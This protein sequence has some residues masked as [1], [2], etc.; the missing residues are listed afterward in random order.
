M[1][2]ATGFEASE[3]LGNMP[4]IDLNFPGMQKNTLKSALAHGRSI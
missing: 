2:L 1:S 3:G 4:G